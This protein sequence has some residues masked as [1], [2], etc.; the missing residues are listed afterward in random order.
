MARPQGASSW[1]S[2]R[3][4]RRPRGPAALGRPLRGSGS[5]AGHS[6]PT[7]PGDCSA[8]GARRFTPCLAARAP[9]SCARRG[10]SAELRRLPPT[11]RGCPP[12]RA[13]A[14]TGAQWTGL[15]PP[16]STMRRTRPPGRTRWTTS[17][18]PVP[19]TARGAGPTRRR[20]RRT[21]WTG[22]PPTPTTTSRPCSTTTARFLLAA[23]RARRSPWSL[24]PQ[25]SRTSRPRA[26][27]ASGAAAPR[28]IGRSRFS[29]TSRR[30][31][32][33]RA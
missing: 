12:K 31:L 7:R 32:R 18:A 20:T 29:R 22:R 14:R 25:A 13:A 3:S 10:H 11:P 4:C 28:T 2:R 23:R 21:P 30:H 1:A 33:R 5:W 16:W 27:T 24:R 6:S 19:R 17:S 15:P 26:A 8:Q 9:A